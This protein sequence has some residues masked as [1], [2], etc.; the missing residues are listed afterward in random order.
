[1]DHPCKR[2]SP[3]GLPNDGTSVSVVELGATRNSW[4][5]SCR[6]GGDADGDGFMRIDNSI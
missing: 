2:I 3:A 5:V 1:M 4:E 6:C